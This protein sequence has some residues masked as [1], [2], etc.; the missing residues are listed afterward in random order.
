MANVHQ[1]ETKMAD[2]ERRFSKANERYFINSDEAL[3]WIRSEWSEKWGNN[4]DVV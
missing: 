3:E 1:D 2:Y 4:A